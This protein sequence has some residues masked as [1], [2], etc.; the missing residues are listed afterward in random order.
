MKNSKDLITMATGASP[1]AD[2]IAA[3]NFLAKKLREPIRFIKASRI[4]GSRTP[5]IEMNGLKWEIK[6]PTK[7]KENTLDHAMKRGLK[8]SKN[9]IFDLRKMRSTGEKAL[10]KLLKEFEKTKEWKRLIIITKDEKILTH[11]K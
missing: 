8:Q 4:H 10:H 5:D 11:E 6:T 1:S 2:E 9:L 3:V 7:A